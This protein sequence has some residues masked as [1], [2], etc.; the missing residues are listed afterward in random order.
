M[1][2]TE[3]ERASIE[4]RYENVRARLAVLR[5]VSPA[6]R[7][8][9]VPGED[10]HIWKR[11]ETLLAMTEEELMNEVEADTVIFVGLYADNP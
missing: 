8:G 3:K 2:I 1:Q 5:H 7:L 10:L 4:A 9:L 11:L 6:E